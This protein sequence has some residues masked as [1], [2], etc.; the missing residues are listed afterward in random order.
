MSEAKEMP[1]QTDSDGL[2]LLE[3]MD[4][5]IDL[6]AEMAVLFFKSAAEQ[7]EGLR[8]GLAGRDRKEIAFKAHKCAGGAAACGFELLAEKLARLEHSVGDMDWESVAAAVDEIGCIYD[9]TRN[10]ILAFLG[11]KQSEI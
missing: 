9:E 10:G 3:T 4:G 7:I 11:A 6:A 5:D 8:T 2:R 1:I